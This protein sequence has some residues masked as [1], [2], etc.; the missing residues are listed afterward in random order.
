[1]LSFSIYHCNWSAALNVV[2][3]GLEGNGK[4]GNIYYKRSSE[5]IKICQGSSLCFTLLLAL[6]LHCDF[7]IAT[8]LKRGALNSKHHNLYPKRHSSI[9]NITYVNCGKKTFSLFLN[10][11]FIL[12]Y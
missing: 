3:G 9:N 10:G 1:M 11:L 8:S 12:G 2:A 5:I 7:Q 4:V 6:T